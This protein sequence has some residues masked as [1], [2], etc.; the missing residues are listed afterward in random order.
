MGKLSLTIIFLLT[1]FI[2][3]AQ[4][5]NFLDQ[6]YLEVAG[7]AD[8]LVTPNEIYIK[9]LITEKDTKDKSSVEE[10]EAKM[11]NALQNLGI[12]IEKALTTSDMV[13]NFRNY[14]LKSKDVLKSKQYIL[15][16]GDAG[17]ASQ[18]FISLEKLEISNTSIDRVDHS[19]LEGIK[20]M[21]RTMAMENARARA[22]ALTKPLKQTIG[23]AIHIIDNEAYNVRQQLQGRVEGVVVRGYSSQGKLKEESPKIEFE[24]INVTT[25]INVKFTLK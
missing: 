5:K 9:I 2:S 19:N 1:T 22:V 11:V 15:K 16:V 13:S 10:Q 18:V 12:P 7:S 23:P 21:M 17:T 3:Q 24:K 8:T 20:N 14:L 6:S 4:T 25:N